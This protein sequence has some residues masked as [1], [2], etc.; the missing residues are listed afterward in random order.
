[1]TTGAP[2]P[3]Q[4]GPLN[5]QPGFGSPLVEEVI[6]PGNGPAPCPRRGTW[7][8]PLKS[9]GRCR[10]N[11]AMWCSRAGFS[12]DGGEMVA[13]H[14]WRIPSL[15]GSIGHPRFAVRAFTVFL[16]SLASYVSSVN[17]F[18]WRRSN[19]SNNL[20][21][22]RTYHAQRQRLRAWN[23]WGRNKKRNFVSSHSVLK[24]QYFLR[25][26]PAWGLGKDT[27]I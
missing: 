25:S 18:P 21:K 2:C 20:R 5:W 17:V 10:A 19:P 14:F 16:F 3:W 27:E 1:M 22:R 6:H 23:L 11:Y 8:K 12:L 9:R 7:K 4:L 15:I 26:S 13:A 24:D